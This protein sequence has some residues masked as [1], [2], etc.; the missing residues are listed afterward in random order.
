MPHRLPP[1]INAFTITIQVTILNK[2]IGTNKNQQPV[3]QTAFSVTSWNI[4][5]N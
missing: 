3:N 5:L 1:V 4:T 2:L